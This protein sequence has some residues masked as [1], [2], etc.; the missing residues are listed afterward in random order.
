MYTKYGSPVVLMLFINRVEIIAGG[1]NYLNGSFYA[2]SS[3]GVNVRGL[4]FATSAGLIETVR[5]PLLSV[6]DTG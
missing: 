4:A 1:S 3:N 5:T 2:V 6:S